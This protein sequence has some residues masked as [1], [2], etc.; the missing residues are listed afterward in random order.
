MRHRYMRVA[1]P[2]DIVNVGTEQWGT[3]LNSTGYNQPCE[4]PTPAS[5][6][7][8]CGIQCLHNQLLL[9]VKCNG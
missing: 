6:C 2:D 5:A 4:L 1:A 3:L 7:H 8:Y 9:A